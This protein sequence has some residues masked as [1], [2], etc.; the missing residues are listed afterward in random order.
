MWF[1][2][3]ITWDGKVIP[4][5]FDKDADHIL[6]NINEDSFR[7]IWTGQRYT[8]FRKGIL[9][10]RK[11]TEICRNCTSGLYWKINS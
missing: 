4:C 6:G 8:I 2:P 1:N 10:G 9:N 3:V 11:M 7:K 5:C